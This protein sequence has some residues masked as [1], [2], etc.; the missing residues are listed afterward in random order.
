MTIDL[1]VRAAASYRPTPRDPYTRHCLVI[2]FP[3]LTSHI[4][5][6]HLS[7]Y[8]GHLLFRRSSLSKYLRVGPPHGHVPG[9]PQSTHFTIVTTC[10]CS[11]HPFSHLST[12]TPFLI[13]FSSP[14]CHLC[15][16]LQPS[17]YSFTEGHLCSRWLFPPHSPHF[18]AS[19]FLTCCTSALLGCAA[20]F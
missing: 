6:S 16:S 2:L 11:T 15:F 17:P 19:T 4:S 3:L 10:S 13:V 14:L 1:E 12:N 7:S 20:L 18:L 8:P 9:T 5:F